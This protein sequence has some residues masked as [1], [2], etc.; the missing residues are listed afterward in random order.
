MIYRADSRPLGQGS[1]TPLRNAPGNSSGISLLV[2]SHRVCRP[3]VRSRSVPGK[4]P[5]GIRT[6]AA[7]VRG[8]CP[9][10][11]DEWAVRSGRQCSEARSPLPERRAQPDAARGRERHTPARSSP[12]TDWYVTQPTRADTKTRAFR[13]AYAASGACERATSRPRRPWPGRWRFRSA[14][15]PHRSPDRNGGSR[16][17]RCS[18]CR[19]RGSHDC[20]GAC[21]RGRTDRRSRAG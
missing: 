6:R 10:P 12:Y 7:A 17:T 19:R 15:A 1:S 9:R 14:A 16:S 5:Y 21:R 18:C 2:D 3:S 4:G 11:L 13:T 20:R 8:R